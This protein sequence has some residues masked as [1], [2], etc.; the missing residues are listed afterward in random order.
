MSDTGKMQ[1]SIH[2]IDLY[3]FGASPFEDITQIIIDE[4]NKDEEKENRF[5]LQKIVGEYPGFN[6]RVYHAMKKTPPRWLEFF[7]SVIAKGE[8]LLKS[9]NIYSTF[10]AFI[11][12]KKNIYAISGGAGNTI[13]DRYK[14][15]K[16][17][18]RGSD[19]VNSKR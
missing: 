17:G 13:L 10:L 8:E 4:T 3:R 16:F 12:F 9:Y 6:I 1:I 19:T 11:G 7:S 14:C 18:N 2:Q 15:I 5:K